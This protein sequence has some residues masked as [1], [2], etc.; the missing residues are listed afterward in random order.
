LEEKIHLHEK[1]FTLKSVIL[2]HLRKRILTGN[3]A[4]VS[5]CGFYKKK[6]WLQHNGGSQRRIPG[7]RDFRETSSGVDDRVTS[8]KR[9]CQLSQ[10]FFPLFI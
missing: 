8:H 6:L 1:R 5:S 7:T 9:C 4:A 3:L 10:I 2:N